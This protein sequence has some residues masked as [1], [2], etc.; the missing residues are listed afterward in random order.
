[1]LVML[2]DCD[3]KRCGIHSDYTGKIKI[4]YSRKICGFRSFERLRRKEVCKSYYSKVPV[5]AY[6]NGHYWKV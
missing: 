1:M 4:D 3:G 5:S 6:E 2:N